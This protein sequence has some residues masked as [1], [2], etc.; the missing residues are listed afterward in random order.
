MVKIFP[1]TIRTTQINIRC[2]ILLTSDLTDMCYRSR[3]FVS[4]NLH[5]IYS[6]MIYFHKFYSKTIFYF[7]RRM[8][9]NVVSNNKLVNN[10]IK[11]GLI[12]LLTNNPGVNKSSLYRLKE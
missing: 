4:Y 11:N 7:F 5:L 12:T 2:N 10:N 3:N 9:R 1:I 8:C 6:T